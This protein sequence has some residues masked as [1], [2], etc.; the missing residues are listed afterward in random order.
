MMFEY[1]N[2][3]NMKI[4]VKMYFFWSNN[5]VLFHFHSWIGD[6][7]H[8]SSVKIVIFD[9]LMKIIYIRWKNNFFPNLYSPS[10]IHDNLFLGVHYERKAKY[11]K[12]RNSFS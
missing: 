6:L 9:V 12:L 4:K 7:E 3:L 10:L 8:V 1:M 2:Y 11:E 5:Y